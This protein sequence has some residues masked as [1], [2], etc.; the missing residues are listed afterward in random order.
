MMNRK[1]IFRPNLYLGES[2]RAEKVEK[3]KKK[4]EKS[5]MF[6]GVFVIALSR[7]SSDQLEIYDAKQ[8]VWPYYQKNPPYVIGIAK[9][10]GE[11]VALIEQIVEEC[12]R[13]RGDCALKEYLQCGM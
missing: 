3:I 6:S 11:A 8:L 5:P 13:H 1:I 12:L 2:I 10:R 4:L 7:N 9:N